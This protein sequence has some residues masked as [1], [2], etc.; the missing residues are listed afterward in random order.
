M[1]KKKKARAIIKL[2]SQESPYMYTTYKNHTNSK[3]RLELQKYDP[4]LR[5]HVAF[6]E[7]K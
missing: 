3:E 1:S 6:K 7:A 2:K 4:N 5:R